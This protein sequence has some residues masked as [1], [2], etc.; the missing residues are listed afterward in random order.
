MSLCV[1]KPDEAVDVGVEVGDDDDMVTI[2]IV[3]LIIT[4][5]NNNTINNIM[6]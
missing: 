2:T 1:T 3:I 5:L 4:N 6:L